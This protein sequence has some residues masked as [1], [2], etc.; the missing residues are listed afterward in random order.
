[1]PTFSGC[2]FAVVFAIVA[3]VAPEPLRNPLLILALI[4]LSACA[5]FVDNNLPG[6]KGKKRMPLILFLPLCLAL[7]AVQLAT[8]AW[9]ALIARTN[10]EANMSVGSPG[11]PANGGDA[12]GGSD[13]TRQLRKPHSK[14]KE[15]GPVFGGVLETR[16]MKTLT[17]VLPCA[18]EGMNAIR[19]VRHFC[20]RT[21]AE[22]LLEIIVVDDGS[23]PPMKETFEQEPSRLDRD[24]RC[25]L[26]ILRHDLTWGLMYAKLTGGKAAKGD[27]VAFI[28]C[29]CAPQP[30]WHREIL[31]KVSANPRAMVVPAI[32]DIDLD[33]FDERANT[34]VN[35]KCY[36]SLQAD[37]KWFDDESD[38]IPTISGGLVAV[39]REWF[40]MTGGFDEDMRG[41][42][43]ENLD[44]SLRSWLCGGE[45]LR[46]K[47]SRVAHMWRTGDQRTGQGRTGAHAPG[48]GGSNRDRFV[49]A[50][51]GPFHQLAG[52]FPLDSSKLETYNKVKRELQCKPLSYFMYRF[53]R[54]Y[55][56]GGILGHTS[57]VIR[58][59]STGLAVTTGGLR[60]CGNGRVDCQRFQRANLDKHTK[61]CCSGIRIADSVNCLDYWNDQR[62]MLTVYS[63]D[64]TGLNG[65][66]QWRFRGDGRIQH[67]EFGDFDCLYV[68]K[69]KEN[70]H[71]QL[72]MKKCSKLAAHEGIFE[73]H[74]H[75][76]PVATRIYQGELKKYHWDKQ[77]PSL[78]DD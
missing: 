50:W 73:E 45:I 24:P 31:E 46:A 39:G 38:Y 42:G 3:D 56:E 17:V 40:N 14:P 22:N 19:T 64:V 5:A 30:G 72:R 27:V 44:Q 28:D 10:S 62:R 4:G 52:V 21:P 71:A 36:L 41:W 18:G 34:Q 6:T 77:F 53:R 74:E 75:K 15:Q 37:F 63:C 16:E 29:H 23:V 66:Q 65:N 51:F 48:R 60:D 7:Y 67:G 70:R 2:S 61:K 76:E 26:K 11:M 49:S 43:I 78:P 54:I 8:I 59:R 35:A 32:T 47:S 1:V 13:N 68:E 69:A 20:T 57:F 9:P 33:T 25:K 55:V 58:E 12:G